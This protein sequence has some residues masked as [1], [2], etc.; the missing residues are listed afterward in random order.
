MGIPGFAFGVTQ[1]IRA[2]DPRLH[3]HSPLVGLPFWG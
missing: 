1:L 3:R 2:Q